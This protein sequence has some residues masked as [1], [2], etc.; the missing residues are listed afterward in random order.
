MEAVILIKEIP[1]TAT[2]DIT[3]HTQ[4]ISTNNPTMEEIPMAAE[5]T[6]T[7]KGTLTKATKIPTQRTL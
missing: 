3:D 5:A 6:A 2:E 1:P 7:D 4:K